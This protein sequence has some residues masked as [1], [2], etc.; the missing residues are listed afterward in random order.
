MKNRSE[1]LP[2]DE[3]VDLLWRPDFGALKMAFGEEEATLA[4]LSL[5]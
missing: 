3:L 4:P 5:P 2:F 1:G